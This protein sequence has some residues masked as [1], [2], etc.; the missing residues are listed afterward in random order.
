MGRLKESNF[1]KGFFEVT[2]EGNLVKLCINPF[3]YRYVTGVSYDHGI[4]DLVLAD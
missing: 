2:E 3:R 1:R 4:T